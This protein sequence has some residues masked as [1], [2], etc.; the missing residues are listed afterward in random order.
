MNCPNLWALICDR[1]DTTYYYLFKNLSIVL[2]V[3]VLGVG[4]ALVIYK[5]V[6]MSNRSNFLLA[7]IWTVFTC[8]VFLSSMHERYGYLLD[9]LTIIYAVVTVKRVWLPV[10]CQLVS[11]RGYCFYLFSYDVLDI[12]I[13]AVIYVAVYAYVT[14]MFVKDVVLDGAK[15]K[16]TANV[17]LKK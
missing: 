6:D 4:L 7:S 14:Y 3:L 2:A 13:V 11:L 15:L 9:I 12:K 8:L 17:K 10:L 16:A 5:R 1:T